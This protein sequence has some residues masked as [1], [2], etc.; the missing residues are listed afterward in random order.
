MSNNISLDK[1]KQIAAMAAAG[2][3]I[4]EIALVV[5]V[6]KQTVSNH[7][8]TR[9]TSLATKNKIKKLLFEVISLIDEL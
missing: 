3:S 2:K 1:K 7:A 8:N 6:A 5:G 9:K 4:R